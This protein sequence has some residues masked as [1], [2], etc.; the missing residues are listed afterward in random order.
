MAGT[1]ADTKATAQKVED[2]SAVVIV[3]TTAAIAAANVT[4]S[5]TD[6]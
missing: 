2:W 3:Q 5:G 6:A 1:T 4:G